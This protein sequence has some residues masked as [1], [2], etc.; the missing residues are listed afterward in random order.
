MLARWFNSNGSFYTKVPVQGA[1]ERLGVG[2]EVVTKMKL[3]FTIIQQNT[4]AGRTQAERE[5]GAGRGFLRMD[6]GAIVG[7]DGF[8]FERPLG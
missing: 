5:S 1:T 4:E 8:A 7:A 3:L 2:T 6:A